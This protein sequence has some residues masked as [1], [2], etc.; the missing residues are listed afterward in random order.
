MILKL[1]PPP[2]PYPAADAPSPPHPSPPLM[3][4]PHHCPT[5]VAPLLSAPSTKGESFFCHFF[6]ILFLSLLVLN[7]HNRIMGLDL[8]S[9]GHLTHGYYTSGGKKISAT[10][11]YFESLPYKL[12]S[13]TGYIDYDRLEEKA[14]DFRPKLIICGGS[15]PRDWDYKRF[16]EVADKC[17]ALLLCDMAHNSGLVAAQ[18]HGLK[19]QGCIMTVLC[20]SDGASFLKDFSFSGEWCNVLCVVGD[21]FFFLHDTN[22]LSLLRKHL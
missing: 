21:V 4:H 14:L 18:M 10:S 15:A 20:P 11:I 12:D 19:K 13:T 7:P 3:P 22:G 2:H 8:P 17:G 9:G 5:S 1:P 6:S 16:R